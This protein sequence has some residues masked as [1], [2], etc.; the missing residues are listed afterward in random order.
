MYDSG[1]LS[2]STLLVGNSNYTSHISSSW[3]RS[4]TTQRYYSTT[5]LGHCQDIKCHTHITG[6]SRQHSIATPQCFRTTVSR[7]CATSAAQYCDTSVS[8]YYSRGGHLMEE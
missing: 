5:I 4:P 3:H 7:D 8:Q 6:V 2:N 1:S